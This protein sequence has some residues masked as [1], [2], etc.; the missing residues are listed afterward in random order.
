[1]S[2]IVRTTIA[3]SMEVEHIEPETAEQQL[4]QRL[5]L[6]EDAIGNLVDD[7][8]TLT[9]QERALRL[10]K[11]AADVRHLRVRRVPLTLADLRRLNITSDAR[12][13]IAKQHGIKLDGRPRDPDLDRAVHIVKAAIAIGDNR[14]PE[15]VLQSAGIKKGDVKRIDAGVRQRLKDRRRAG[16]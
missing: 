6:I 16:A 2:K 5:M 1:M 9:A 11:I 12:D 15:E 3:G 4:D 7:C 13:A 10:N 14:S 8:E